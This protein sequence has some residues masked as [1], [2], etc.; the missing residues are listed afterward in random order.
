MKLL[1]NNS[2][3]LEG[4]KVL[5]DYAKSQGVTVAQLSE[6]A[7]QQ[8]FLNAALEQGNKKFGEAG[9]QA[10]P[11]QGGIKKLALAFDDLK[12]SIAAVVNSGL[13]EFFASTI[14]GTANAIQTVLKS[15]QELSGGPK[16]IAE[17]ISK[18][19]AQITRLNEMKMGN[20]NT[21]E[22][23]QRLADLKAKLESLK[24]VQESINKA[25]A[26]R[27]R[28]NAE[29]AQLSKAEIVAGKGDAQLQARLEKERQAQAVIS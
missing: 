9:A 17:D 19:E 29:R 3:R 24:A 2:I 27:D 15:F 5:Q 13:G 25:E 14:S 12:D 18:V 16:T 11:I 8:A 6:A 22:F 20:L 1:R 28:Q 21:N 7:K 23:D 4:D 10:A 26:E